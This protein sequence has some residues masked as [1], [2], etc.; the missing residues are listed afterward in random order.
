M[1]ES[2]SQSVSHSVSQS[3][4]QCPVNIRRLTL[5]NMTAI[6]IWGNIVIYVA[7]VRIPVS[8]KLC[9]PLKLCY[10]LNGRYWLRL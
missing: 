6:S 7:L 5:T 9:L 4:S 2:V 1:S 3:V 10:P 8:Y